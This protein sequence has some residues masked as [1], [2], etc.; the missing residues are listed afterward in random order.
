MRDSMK[1]SKNNDS[2]KTNG[3]LKKG[4]KKGKVPMVLIV[5]QGF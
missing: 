5:V 1:K 3:F 2:E 4:I